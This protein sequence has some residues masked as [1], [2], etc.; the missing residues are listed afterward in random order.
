MRNR[1][2]KVF[3][4]MLAMA[5]L[6]G[7]SPV[8]APAALS[9]TE[10]T[11]D[12][13]R[14]SDEFALD[15]RPITVDIGGR[16]QIYVSEFLKE[17][18]QE[19]LFAS[20]AEESQYPGLHY[21]YWVLQ[22]VDGTLG[23]KYF[24]YGN[25]Y[26]NVYDEK[27]TGLDRI[28]Y[29]ENAVIWFY[30]RENGEWKNVTLRNGMQYVYVF[31]DVKRE[32][33]SDGIFVYI[34]NGEGTVKIISLTDTY[35]GDGNITIPD[36]A[37]LTDP[38]TGK[39]TVYTVTAIGDKAFEKEKRIT[40]V[41]F[42]NNGTLSVGESA[43][44]SAPNLTRISTA[45]EGAIRLAGPYIF[46]GEEALTEAEIRVT[47]GNYQSA[48]QECGK[49]ESLIIRD[50]SESASLLTGASFYGC[51]A[52]KELEIH[53]NLRG[54]T[55]MGSGFPNLETLEIESESAITLSSE[56]LSGM[57]S[58]KEA[59]FSGAPV[60]IGNYAF[61][62]DS[63]L[64]TALFDG[65]I[66][67]IGYGAFSGD[68]SLKTF[69]AETSTG[70]ITID[71][72]AFNGT[73]ALETFSIGETPV[74]RIGRYAFTG[75]G[76]PGT[77]RFKADN[78]VIDSCAFEHLLRA[79]T[80]I[81]DGN[82]AEFSSN[83]LGYW[84]DSTWSPELHTVIVTGKTGEIGKNAF[85]GLPKLKAAVFTGGVGSFATEV[86]GGGSMD[87][88]RAPFTFVYV[89]D[90]GSTTSF[91]EYVVWANRTGNVHMYF[92]MPEERVLDAKG[93]LPNRVSAYYAGSSL[94][95]DL[96]VNL[97]STEEASARKG[98]EE[99][100]WSSVEEAAERLN[101]FR[102]GSGS[103]LTNQ[104]L[105]DKAAAGI[106]RALPFGAGDAKPVTL[107]I[108]STEKD[109]HIG[110]TLFANN[111]LLKAVSVNAPG[112]N[113]SVG[114]YAFRNCANLEALT[115]EA[116]VG[117][118]ETDWYSFENTALEALDLPY[119]GDVKIGS[120]SFENNGKL[121]QVRLHNPVLGKDNESHGLILGNAFAGC[122][123]LESFESDVRYHTDSGYD[124]GVAWGAF[125]DDAKLERAIFHG[126]AQIH[127]RA[128]ENCTGLQVLR[129]DY[130]GENGAGTE[131]GAFPHLPAG[132][133]FVA[134]GDTA[135]IGG[136]A[137]VCLDGFE[138]LIFS[139]KQGEGTLKLPA[140]R[141]IK[142]LYI[143]A[144][145]DTAGLEDQLSSLPALQDVYIAKQEADVAN[146]EELR[147]K[148][149]G[150][151]I[152]FLEN[153]KESGLFISGTGS[154]ETGDGTRENPVRTFGKLAELFEDFEPGTVTTETDAVIA[155]L[156]AGVY[157]KAGIGKTPEEFKTVYTS[158]EAA[159]VLG[160][161]KV[162]GNETWNSPKDVIT[163]Y[164]DPSFRGIM[165]ENTG[166]LTLGNVVLDGNRDE[167]TADGEILRSTGT[168]N[169]QE[170]AV[171]RNNIR[172]QE[173]YP[174]GAGGIYASG[175]I[176]MTGGEISGNTGVYGGGIEVIGSST[177]F[178][179]SGGRIDGNTV[180]GHTTSNYG[181]GVLVASGA[182]MNL[183]GGTI[184]NNAA[185]EGY[186]SYLG[187]GGGGISVGGGNT[188]MC[189]KAT[190]N[191]TGG[192]LSGNRAYNNG[193]GIYIEDNCLAYV[194]GGLLTG[195]HAQR[196]MFG[197]GAIYVNGKRA[198]R[199]GELHLYNVL[200]E[201]NTASY[202]GGGIAGC[203]T[204][205]VNVYQ[206]DGGAIYGNNAEDDTDIYLDTVL[207]YPNYTD[208]MSG[209]ASA[210]MFNGAP[211]NWTDVRTGEKVTKAQLANLRS[212]LRDH[213]ITL[214]ANP[215]GTQPTETDAAVVITGNT[216]GSRGGGVGSNGTV[217]IGTPPKPRDLTWT[218]EI[219]KILYARDMQEGE[220]FNFTVYEE[221]SSIGFNFWWIQ[222]EDVKA[223]TGSVTGGKDGKPEAIRFSE[224][225][226]GQVTAADIGKSRTFLILE[227][228]PEA[229]DLFTSGQYLAM[230][231]ITS[232]EWDEETEREV[233]C[234]EV[235]K[236]ETGRVLENGDL[237]YS[238]DGPDSLRTATHNYG[239]IRRETTEAVFRN[240]AEYTTLTAEKVWEDGGENKAPENGKVVFELY[241]DDKPTGKR[242]TLDGTADEKGE[243]ES[244][245]ARWTDVPVYRTD[246]SGEYYKIHETD[247]EY[248]RVEYAI[249]EISCEPKGWTP[250][251]AGDKLTATTQEASLPVPV[252]S[253][254]RS[255]TITNVHEPEE[256]PTPT[257]TPTPT[258]T[259]EPTPTPTPN[260]PPAV[261]EVPPEK[262]Q[263][264]VPARVPKWKTVE[265]YE[266]ETALGGETTINHVGDC[267]D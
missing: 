106:D 141:N 19:D 63:A 122:G 41:T 89:G 69:T 227:D 57:A 164:R 253:L 12:S 214:K 67:H 71:T 125:Y 110:N 256:T 181:G 180:S 224:I 91:D 65:G 220:T 242:I 124:S 165:V 219:S 130:P 128:F 230:N 115:F 170:G 127:F 191:M 59:H 105:S 225:D 20:Y 258:E 58:L 30:V 72:L 43:F 234:T 145:Y 169:I 74:K 88:A 173:R 39:E 251:T 198:V 248:A 140:G 260:P 168:L 55:S 166:T 8:S 6:L 96:Y 266:Y 50:N 216:S 47:G 262:P 206:L 26:G 103:D 211:C 10:D 14:M 15:D 199:D 154:D 167:V 237:E 264:K 202:E 114:S 24:Y 81:F 161:V 17:I 192:T 239:R 70:S 136:P 176:T 2:K 263:P 100:P 35:A 93:A 87:P 257:P 99:H 53:G 13:A 147:S 82:V 38:E 7:I 228:K 9:E 196:G 185:E 188:G 193:G 73:S 254:T 118:F 241:A 158:S 66:S 152:H 163:L 37:T 143:G 32:R 252:D 120:H 107:H 215:D 246:S 60:N 121:R 61:R 142:T 86:F 131:G 182:V 148:A 255:V 175:R 247:D 194:S 205:T 249:L 108:A 94:G 235:Q 146:A 102:A 28:R 51:K 75:S 134:D 56:A 232:T 45:G 126:A 111:L 210:Y 204:S 201:G 153:R 36:T 52:L 223:G 159:F 68:T 197:G 117:S 178:D 133:S 243:A 62:E 156:L 42:A 79:K 29:N 98:T 5:M 213:M 183:S 34:K 174:D 155:P 78:M 85:Y 244:W 203:S 250:K 162:T 233:L 208:S 84:T 80:L 207:T 23:Y 22:S 16:E 160:T 222:Y 11:S 267:F 54:V 149:Q 231:V 179:M 95:E 184:S 119:S 190:L 46:Y 212:L 123:E 132:A 129:V 137:Q 76:V 27:I 200:I 3:A 217:I 64:E 238:L 171:V 172:L 112:K 21:A 48:F 177:V 240:Y 116:P 97:D 226:L 18:G 33:M 77:L 92:N 113:F 189:Q 101:A 83:A 221:K 151:R 150:I 31:Q 144:E 187:A 104:F 259:P 265:L 236:T 218:P 186:S 4:F 1:L 135:T 139:G 245:K 195:N 138:N 157:A 109:I 49:L 40:A 229:E 261:P 209:Y 90:N 44:D 25:Y